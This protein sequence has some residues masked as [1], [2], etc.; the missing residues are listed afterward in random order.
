M[1]AERDT[2]SDN[3][4]AV[5]CAALNPGCCTSCNDSGQIVHTHARVINQL[6]FGTNEKDDAVWLGS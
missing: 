3:G 2:G 4:L 5:E 1:V 6:Y